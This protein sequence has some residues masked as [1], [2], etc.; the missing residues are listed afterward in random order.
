VGPV[1][2]HPPTCPVDTLREVDLR[3][4]AETVRAS[5]V[6][7][8][9]VVVAGLLYVAATWS[10]P[11]RG[12]ITAL[13][14]TGAVSMWILGRLPMARIVRSR[15][16]ELFFVSWSLMDL[17]LIAVAVAADGGVT[18]PLAFM[19]FFPLV[20]TSLS[21]PPSSI[22]LVYLTAMTSYAVVGL[23]LTPGAGLPQIA[24]GASILALA[25]FIGFLQARRHGR[26]RHHL[27]VSS[28]TDALTGLLNHTAFQE[29]LG[30]ELEHAAV[31]RRPLALIALDVDRFKAVN[32]RHGHA[33]GDAALRTVAD[34]LRGAVRPGDL[35]G[36][37]GGDEFMLALPGVGLDQAE[38]VAARVRRAVGG[39]ALGLTV[40]AGIAVSPD[41][42]QD[43][44]ELMR[45]A[46]GAMYWSKRRG[47]DRSAAYSPTAI[48][49]LSP[50]EEVDRL[51]AEGLVR[52][53]HALARAVDAKDG[54][55]HEHS[56]KVADYATAIGQGM[57]LDQGTIDALHTAGV[58]HD[59][60]KIGVPDAILLKPGKLSSAEYGEMQRHSR[61]GRDIIAGAGLTDI[62]E[63]VCHLHE[64]VDG[65]GYPDGLRGTQI[66]LESRVLAVADALEA[67]TAARV[68]RG[69]L[70]V[71]RALGILEEAA[72]TQFDPAV[73][74]VAVG[75]VRDGGL[76]ALAAPAP[77][78]TR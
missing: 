77:A 24:M 78:A 61:L 20:F 16:R 57:R 38:V 55:T 22:A 37:T 63:W 11:H 3:Y 68:Y 54:H 40:S 64:R 1:S 67:M 48:D 26:E 17:V 32:D 34:A 7:T 49:S 47:R 44:E 72:G 4:R 29:R 73:V 18:S 28:R 35:C 9:G 19:F 42:A 65:R 6:P 56:R 23:G 58:L 15:R 12:L 8:Y 52:T 36:R 39:S 71:E 13:F 69:A 31:A 21:Y 43:R 45:F 46:D 33:S 53:V 25:P 70:T 41:H 62:A 51:R 50:E 74:A 76:E 5:M 59:V 27:T 10:Q 14:V 60:G 30:E 75:L 2:P 66:P